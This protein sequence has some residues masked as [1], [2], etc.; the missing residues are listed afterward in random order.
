MLNIKKQQYRFLSK[1]KHILYM[2]QY[3]AHRLNHKQRTGPT[4]RSPRGIPV[5]QDNALNGH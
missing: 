5:G 2:L 3:G 4:E 1:H